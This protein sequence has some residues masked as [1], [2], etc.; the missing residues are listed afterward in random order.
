MT[1]NKKIMTGVIAVVAVIVLVFSASSMFLTIQSGEKGVIFRRFSGGL[2]TVKTFGQGF[3]LIAPWNVMYV[4]D[5]RLQEMAERMDVMS[6]NG[7]SILV[8]VS[9]RYKPME[10]SV[11]K[12]HNKI[13]PE[14]LN[15]I[16]IPEVRSAT[17][18]VIGKYTP[19][20]L[21]SAKREI[22]Q[23]EIFDL[24]STVLTRN[25]IHLDAVLI[26][27]VELPPTLRT[28]IEAK[29]KQEQESQEYEFRIEKESKEADRKR[30][31]A[32]GINDFQ[33]IVSDGISEKLLKWKGIE[34]TQALANS[35][36]AKIVVIG[37]GKDGLPII[38]GGN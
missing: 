37:S 16:I 5:V 4:Y 31:E 10:F 3:H 32:Q 8:D 25:N 24:T 36:N 7:L 19:E 30:I 38:L 23:T 20:D 26:R 13:G 22:I 2:D 17:R 33:K 29:L 18:L 28:A 27:S 6:N 9:L 15:R 14:Y 12:L 1:E 21:Y 35:P 11:G 34:A